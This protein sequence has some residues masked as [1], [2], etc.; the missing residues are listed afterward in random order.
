MAISFS[1]STLDH[2]NWAHRSVAT[3]L[4]GDNEWWTVK[5]TVSMELTRRAH[6]RWNYCPL[7][8]CSDTMKRLAGS[9]AITSPINR[10]EFSVLIQG[11]SGIDFK[12]GSPSF[13]DLFAFPFYSNF[14]KNKFRNVVLNN[15]RF[16]KVYAWFAKFSRLWFVFGDVSTMGIFAIKT[17]LL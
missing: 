5:R 9:Y 14:A 7:F 10:I 6:V 16:D 2:K 12:Q 4:G 17:I 13:V 8:C 11:R 15:R 1:F 3:Y